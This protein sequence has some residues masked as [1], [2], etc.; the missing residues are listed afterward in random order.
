LLY[1]RLNLV[2]G[3]F[4][5][6]LKFYGKKQTYLLYYRRI[7]LH[8]LPPIGMIIEFSLVMIKRTVV[9]TIFLSIILCCHPGWNPSF[10]QAHCGSELPSLQKL[11]GNVKS[12]KQ[13]TYEAMEKFGKVEMGP[14]I[15]DALHFY[16]RYNPKGQMIEEVVYASKGFRMEGRTQWVY[17]SKGNDVQVREFNSSGY[18]IAQ[19]LK[20]YE[21]GRLKEKTR[22]DKDQLIIYT[23][24]YD[25]DQEG[26]WTESSQYNGYGELEKKVIN[27]YDSLGN[28]IEYGYY[29]SNGALIEKKTYVLDKHDRELEYRLFHSG[30]LEIKRVSRYDSL[31]R[32]RQVDRFTETE[33]NWLDRNVYTY[34][35][36]GQLIKRDFL[37]AF[38]AITKTIY[39]YNDRGRISSSVEY[40]AKDRIKREITY[41]YDDKGRLLKVLAHHPK[42]SIRKKT[43][44]EY[45][46][47]G[48]WTQKVDYK[49][50]IPLTITKR[51]ILYY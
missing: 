2:L 51:E 28:R 36:E 14:K 46:S 37:S 41:Q 45:D 40:D 17:D 10:A 30:G 27:R 38:G 9:G 22:L 21:D 42:D 49:N 48:N 7:G 24:L 16:R 12:V 25:Y 32:L 35:R 26:N 3:R 1:K 19:S 5:L 34:N 18:L 29:D 39:Q 11:K 4:F 13:F 8:S 43:T 33:V 23:V 50:E 20:I 44:Y 6:L 47:W 31:G 15:K